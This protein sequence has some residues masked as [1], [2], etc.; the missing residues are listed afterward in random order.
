MSEAAAAARNSDVVFLYEEVDESNVEQEWDLTYR[1][2]PESDHDDDDDDDVEN[3]V[4]PLRFSDIDEANKLM[5]AQ[6]TIV[7]AEEDEYRLWKA[8]GETSNVRGRGN[9]RS[10]YYK[11]KQKAE[12]LKCSAKGSLDI[13]RFLNVREEEE[14]EDSDDTIDQMAVNSNFS[15]EVLPGAETRYTQ[16]QALEALL[17]L[18]KITRN[19]KIE[20][21]KD[22]MMWEHQRNLAVIRYLQLRIAGEGKI[23]ASV[24]SAS[25]YYDNDGMGSYKSR[26]IRNWSDSYL[27]RGEFGIY[28]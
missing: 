9:G 13:R 1:D 27:Q 25:N 4:E 23:K 2:M 10:T 14:E 7:F 26:S 24:S 15:I 16:E 12:D 8:N 6:T 21:K 17:P 22:Q 3:D 19:R 20:A 18:V 5:E 28:R 11:N